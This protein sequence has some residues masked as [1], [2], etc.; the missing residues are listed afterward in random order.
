MNI[1]TANRKKH[2]RSFLK[3]VQVAF[4]FNEPDHFQEKAKE[5]VLSL[6]EFGFEVAGGVQSGLFAHKHKSFVNCTNS[7]IALVVEASDYDS[8]EAFLPIVKSILSKIDI[9]GISS[10]ESILFQKSNTFIFRKDLMKGGLTEEKI[11]KTL[12]SELFLAQGTVFTGGKLED[13]VTLAMRKFSEEEKRFV[14]ELQVS[15]CFM[16]TC[17]LNK[18]DEKLTEINNDI[19]S[20]WYCSTSEWLHK[21][22]DEV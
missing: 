19:Y 4:N 7:S 18:I 21:Y 12:F 11:N 2:R 9:L 20:M 17:A 1:P 14:V 6:G 22:M 16:N 15:G 10:F 3:Y 5:F 8:F 13:V